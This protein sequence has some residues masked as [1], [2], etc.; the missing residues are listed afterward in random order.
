MNKRIHRD[1]RSSVLKEFTRL[2]KKYPKLNR[3]V[4]LKLS[5]AYVRAL[6]I[7]DTELVLR[8]LVRAQ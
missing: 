8:Q 4:K 1:V 5:V 6:A 7:A 2:N 3:S